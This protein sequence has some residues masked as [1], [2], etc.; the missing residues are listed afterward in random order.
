MP[1]S[2]TSISTRFR[3][4]G[5]CV[6]IAARRFRQHD[7]RGGNRPLERTILVSVCEGCMLHKAQESSGRRLVWEQSFRNWGC[8]ECAWV[9]EPSGS[10]PGNSLDK[11]LLNFQVQLSEEFESHAC[12][13]HQGSKSRSLPRSE[14]CVVQNESHHSESGRAY[15][16]TLPLLRS[17]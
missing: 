4:A 11:I 17:G 5:S 15:A 10:P 13:K 3:F 1:R 6:R 9:F 14:Q 12:A 8:S 16:L 2:A 7:P